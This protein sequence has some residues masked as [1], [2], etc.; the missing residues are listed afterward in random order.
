MCPPRLNHADPLG[1]GRHATTHEAS[2]SRMRSARPPARP[3]PAWTVLLRNRDFRL[4]FVAQL[5]SY[6]GDWFLFVALADLIYS[7]THSAGM[8]ALL[9]AA[10]TVPATLLTFV[11]GPLADRLDRQRLM[12]VTD[13]VRGLLALG[14][15][16][17]RS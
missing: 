12:V 13:A 14:F 3:T 8:V 7:L 6:A 17:V 16:L 10:Q 9:L 1:K 5:I 2:M 11:G 4:M 15:F